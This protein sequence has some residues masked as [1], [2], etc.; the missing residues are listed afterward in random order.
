MVQE[1]AEV[2]GSRPV[3]T[4]PALYGGTPACGRRSRDTTGLATGQEVLLQQQEGMMLDKRK[5]KRRKSL[6]VLR[7]RVLWKKTERRDI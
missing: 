6:K 4:R 3:S 5:R 2:Q 7:F 1:R